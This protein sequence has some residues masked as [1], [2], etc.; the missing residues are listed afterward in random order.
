VRDNTGRERRTAEGTM[1]VRLYRARVIRGKEE[2]FLAF[3]RDEAMPFIDRA[4]AV[5]TYFGRRVGAS[6][7]DFVAISVWE[8]LAALERAVPEWRR[9][10]PF[11]Q[12]ETMLVEGNVEHFET[13]SGKAPGPDG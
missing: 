1:I 6:G 9:P 10:I 7:E 3:L 12:A 11:P 4:G 8:N 2:A 5:A 13:V